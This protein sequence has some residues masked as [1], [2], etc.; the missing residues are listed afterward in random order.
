MHDTLLMAKKSLNMIEK[1][2][3][4]NII[5]YYIIN[6]VIPSIITI[7]NRY[8]IDFGKPSIEPGHNSTLKSSAGLIMLTYLFDFL[9]SLLFHL[10][11]WIK[12]SLSISW[13]WAQNVNQSQSNSLIL[14]QNWLHRDNSKITG[15]QIVAHNTKYWRGFLKTS[16][17]YPL[18]KT[19]GYSGPDVLVQSGSYYTLVRVQWVNQH[20]SSPEFYGTKNL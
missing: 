17:R 18:W 13:N 8:Q 10:R 6:C 2:I 19:V 16:Q 4:P 7:E 20:Q 11:A 3:D 14:N 12:R 15:F 1:M 9:F 5:D